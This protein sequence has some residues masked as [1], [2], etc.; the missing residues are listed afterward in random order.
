LKGITETEA[1]ALLTCNDTDVVD[2]MARAHRVR[3]EN[4]GMNVELCGIL[5]AKSGMCSE[6]CKF[7]P[8]S[9]HSNSQVPCYPLVESET[10]VDAARIAEK[11]R[12]ARFGIVTSGESIEE[13]DEIA[14][15]ESAISTIG[16]HTGILPCASLGLVSKETLLRFKNAGL[17]RYHCNL[18]SA[19]SFFENICTTHKWSDSRD[20]IRTAK[21][22]GLSVCSGGIFGMGETLQQRVELLSE[23]RELDVDSVPL[24]F[25]NPV[26]GTPLADIAPPSA[27]EC[28][29]IVA[30]ARLMM[31]SKT[32]RICGGREINLRD[33]QSWALAA[34]ADGLMV[35]GYLTTKGR[36]VEDDL[37]MIEDAGFT[38]ITGQ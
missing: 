17:T 1:L 5:N 18:E 36:A 13:S 33:L 28:I 6:N 4:K 26:K 20:T 27:L 34:G 7:C 38:I 24:N 23:I 22:I 15:I 21:S 37:R 16:Q 25:L 19:K 2:L 11:H 29:R 10:M 32:I 8:Q 9:V 14:V 30:V 31:P 3:V 35:G 12:A